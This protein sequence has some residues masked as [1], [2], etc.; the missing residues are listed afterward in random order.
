MLNCRSAIR[1]AT[2]ILD[3]IVQKDLDYLALTETWF[4]ASS[5]PRMD[6]LVPPGYMILS[7]DRT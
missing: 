5:Q 4:S 2:A 1:H 7:V 3:L 6:E